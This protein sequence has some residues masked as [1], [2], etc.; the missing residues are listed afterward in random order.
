MAVLTATSVTAVLMASMTRPCRTATFLIQHQQ[1]RTA[2]AHCRSRT[3]FASTPSSASCRS[4]D[5]APV[6]AMCVWVSGIP[7][8]GYAHAE[9]PEAFRKLPTLFSEAGSARLL[10]HVV[11]LRI[12]RSCPARLPHSPW[13]VHV[14]LRHCGRLVRRQRSFEGVQRCQWDA[15]FSTQT[16]S[17][18]PVPAGHQESDL[19]PAACH[20]GLGRRRSLLL[21][22]DVR[23]HSPKGEH[24]LHEVLQARHV[25]LHRSHIT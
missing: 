6:P 24:T 11:A 22:T 12:T 17:P 23:L 16:A 25:Q 14:M 4:I 7:C 20:I 9:P 5:A 8:S 3:S 1:G 2:T 15:L 19:S 21:R 10:P 13:C 18:G